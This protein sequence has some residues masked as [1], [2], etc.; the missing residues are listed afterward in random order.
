MTPPNDRPHGLAYVFGGLSFIPLLGLPFGIAAVVWGLVSRRP[1]GRGLA[2]IGA[3][4]IA[5]SVALYAGLYWFGFVQ[6]GGLYDG[7]RLRLAQAAIDDLVPAIE[8]YKLQTGAYPESLEQL[9]AS[10]PAN[11][12]S[13][14][15]DPGVSGQ[16]VPLRYF[17][18]ERV[19]D[20][21]YY[22]RGVGPDRIA[23]T[24]DDLLPNVTVVE[25]S[26]VGLLLA[27]HHP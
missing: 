7:M 17:F 22:L 1:G 3:G 26:K 9:H 19:D 23:F 12:F 25:G 18:Y 14:A 11:N 13:A 2:A 4:G 15:F 5:L 6:T 10:L 20:D 16:G 27:R 24:A 21:H 8:F